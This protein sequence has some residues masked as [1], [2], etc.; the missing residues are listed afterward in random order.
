[1]YLR[2]IKLGD[3]V[4][5]ELPKSIAEEYNIGHGDSILVPD[6]KYRNPFADFRVI[7]KGE[8]DQAEDQ[9]IE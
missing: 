3:A 6:D 9:E 2:A 8:Q 1:M 5:V 7:H 4:Y